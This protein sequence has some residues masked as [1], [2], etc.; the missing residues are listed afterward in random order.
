LPELPEVETIVRSLAP[1][2]TGRRVLEVHVLAARVMRGAPE[3]DLQGHEVREVRRHGKHILLRFDHGVLAI[4]LG[5]T[6]KLL[7][8]GEPTPYLRAEFVLDGCR[9]LFDDIRQFGRM[10]WS[11]AL[12]ENVAR[13]GPDPL[14]LSVA[15]FTGR[16]R[17]RAMRVK[18]LLLD[19]RFLRGLG[20]IYVDEALHR[21]GVHPLMPAEAI[22]KARARRLYEAMQAVLREAIAGGGSSISDYVDTEGRRGAFQESHR[23]YGRAGEACPACGAAV[24][25]IVVAQRGTHF[26]PRCQR[27]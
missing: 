27:M 24:E 6:G 20:N 11:H 15:E 10:A 3:P 22:S 19:Q 16:L 14:E 13:L 5:M 23:V 8:D 1:R 2:I 9:L 25:R 17:G 18:P 21:A 7:L 12:P 26:C 4:H